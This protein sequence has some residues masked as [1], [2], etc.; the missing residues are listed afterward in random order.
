[1]QEGGQKIQA[2]GSTRFRNLWPKMVQIAPPEISTDS[3]TRVLPK[4]QPYPIFVT[5]TPKSKP[6]DITVPKFTVLIHWW[7][8]NAIF[9]LC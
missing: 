4:T 3:Y 6:Y 2:T 7:V 1:M 9:L 5:R 8:V